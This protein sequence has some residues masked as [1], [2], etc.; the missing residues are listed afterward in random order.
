MPRSSAAP[1]ASAQSKNCD[2]LG[3]VFVAFVIF[4]FLK[5]RHRSVLWASWSLRRRGE[6]HIAPSHVETRR[7]RRSPRRGHE[8]IAI[9]DVPPRDLRALRGSTRCRSNPSPPPGAPPLRRH[10][11][12][13]LTAIIF[14]TFAIFS[15]LAIFAVENE[16]RSTYLWASWR[17]RRGSARHIAASQVERGGGAWRRVRT[18][19]RWDRESKI[20][21]EVS[22]NPNNAPGRGPGRHG[23][24]GLDGN[25][26][27]RDGFSLS[28]VDGPI[29]APQV[30]CLERDAE[31]APDRRATV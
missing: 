4:V 10:P 3:G 8:A 6:Q 20:S 28:P 13:R 11:P 1:A 25:A 5:Q 31:G 21:C 15:T 19:M 23:R 22:E 16:R 24:A 27:G 17:L 9:L 29:R 14:A 30:H 26:E 2:G 18:G 7:A 12:S